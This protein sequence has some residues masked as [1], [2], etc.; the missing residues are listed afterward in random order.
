MT[1]PQAPCLNPDNRAYQRFAA[2]LN[3][4][5]DVMNWHRDDNTDGV[6][7]MTTVKDL[8]TGDLFTLALIDSLEEAGA[9]VL[10]A[11]AEDGHLSA[12]GPFRG[13]QA[14]DR[15]AAQLALPDPG[16]A[17]TRACPL[18]D[19]AKAD[20]PATWTPVPTA[21]LATLRS[22]P[23]TASPAV[24]VLLDHAAERL[25]VHGPFP[26]HASA[27]QWHD[28]ANPVTDRLVVPLHQADSPH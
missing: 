3:E 5:F 16:L 9:A 28:A 15:H 19:P 26:T 24:L 12:Y 23:D 4:H 7:V 2:L 20:L 10:L 22:T 27:D 8:R 14:A 18:H 25:V 1:N 21:I 17:Y 6:P 11:I 13:E